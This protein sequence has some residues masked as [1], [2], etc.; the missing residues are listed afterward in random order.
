MPVA[1]KNGKSDSKFIFCHLL[2][3]F[4]ISCHLIGAFGVWTEPES[5][6]MRV[7]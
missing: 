4:V 3:R 2:S 7:D 6:L 5:A 1:V